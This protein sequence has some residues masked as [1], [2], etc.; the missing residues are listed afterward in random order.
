MAFVQFTQ[1]DDKPVVINTERIV[2]AEADSFD[3][4]Q[5]SRWTTNSAL[6]TRATAEPQRQATR[7]KSTRTVV[8]GDRAA[9]SRE[10]ATASSGK[11]CARIRS[12]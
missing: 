8:P 2:T 11:K 1:P 12:V 9:P 10:R 5:V 4:C 7:S 3:V 6:S